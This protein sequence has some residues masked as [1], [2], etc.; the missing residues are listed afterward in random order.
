MP[1][2][3]VNAMKTESK[4]TELDMKIAA[5]LRKYRVRC[6]YSQRDIAN[7][8]DVTFQQVQKYED[9]SN[10]ISASNLF[11]VCNYL[12]LD[13][14]T[15]FGDVGALP[16]GN[17]Q[18]KEAIKLERLISRLAPDVRNALIRIIQA[19]SDK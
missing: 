19:M 9:A 16:T 10:R 7:A 3:G 12:E 11:A 5:V 13:I 2:N 17:K 8:I 14:D 1:K 15:F 6:G 4:S 18:L